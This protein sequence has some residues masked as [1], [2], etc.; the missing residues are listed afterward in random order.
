MQGWEALSVTFAG[1]MRGGMAGNHKLSSD[2]FV[3][4]QG[5]VIRQGQ[6]QCDCLQAADKA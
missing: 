1:C 2:Q 3:G 4:G 5:Q 6:Q